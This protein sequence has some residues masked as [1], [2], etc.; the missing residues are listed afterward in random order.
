MSLELGFRNAGRD[1]A[2]TVI[3]EILYV[4]LGY[5]VTVLIARMAG[6]EALGLYSLSLVILNVGEVCSNMGFKQANLRFIPLYLGLGYKDFAKGIVVFGL[7]LVGLTAAMGA[8]LLFGFSTTKSGYFRTHPALPD[9]M[10]LVT[11]A[12]PVLALRGVG[13]FAL[14]GFK[15][16]RQRVLADKVIDPGIRLVSVGLFFLLGLKVLGGV[17]AMLMGVLASTGAAFYWLKVVTAGHLRT[18][19]PRYETRSWLS[20]SIPLMFQ[21]LAVFLQ[22]SIPLL[23]LEYFQGA[24][25]VGIFSA[26]IKVATLVSLPLIGL[27]TVFAPRVAEQSAEVAK[28]GR[29]YKAMT[30]WTMSISLLPFLGI[31]FAAGSI[32]K[33]F[34]PEFGSYSNLLTLLAVGYLVWAGNGSAGCILV[35]TGRAKVSLL[36]AILGVVL[37]FLLNLWLIPSL[38]IQGAAIAN[39]VVL[40]AGSLLALGEVFYLMR[41]QPYGRGSL[42]AVVAGA[43]ATLALLLLARLGDKPTQLALSTTI[44]LVAFWVLSS[45]GEKKRYYRIL[46]TAMENARQ[47]LRSG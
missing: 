6:T 46:A 2:V 43:A 16:I 1:V 5:G 10:K 33:I 21:S 47:I 31:L 15:A 8:V 35:M 37:S 7:R 3:G 34:G 36:N 19:E 29:L 12:L 45:D 13:S 24:T 14:L 32:M 42:R 11:I 18:T 17:L 40:L 41:L 27:N 38:G 30:A 28:L 26:A 20:Y 39:T 4:V 25:Q 44:Y 9:A 23:L 22:P